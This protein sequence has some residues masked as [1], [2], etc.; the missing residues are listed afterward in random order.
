MKKKFIL[1]VMI[2]S[3]TMSFC[4]CSNVVKSYETNEK[5][6][7]INDKIYKGG[8]T[9]SQSIKLKK[10]WL[11]DLIG[12]NKVILNFSTFEKTPRH[13]LTYNKNNKTLKLFLKN[14]SSVDTEIS[15]AFS[16]NKF[17]EDVDIRDNAGENTMLIIY[18]TKKEIEYR[19]DESKDTN[20]LVLNLRE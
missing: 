2:L 4:S 18:L 6:K 13:I 11:N 14:V 8:T 10:I 17:I 16:E 5:S 1:A 9:S 15:D 7:Y 20:Q 12:D 3:I 19:V